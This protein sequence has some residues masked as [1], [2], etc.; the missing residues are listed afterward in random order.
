MSSQSARRNFFERPRVRLRAELDVALRRLHGKARLLVGSTTHSDPAERHRLCQCVARGEHAKPRWEWRPVAIERSVWRELARARELAEA[1]EAAALYLPRL[2]E[3]EIELLLLES[4]GR[5]KQVRP[6]AARLF[7]TGSERLFPDS[8]HSILD[9]AHEILSNASLEQ[10][11]KT[12]PAASVEGVNLRDLMLAY[13][14][15]VGLHIAV[16]I[17]P[18]LIANAAVGERTVFIAD[19]CFGAHEAQRLATHEVY[20]H[21]VS[22]F[23]GR[24]QTLGIFSIGTAGSYGDQEGVAIYLEELAG[25]LDSSRQRTLAGRLLATHAMHA[26]VSFGDAARV[27]VSEHD[28][29]PEAAVTLCER[30]FRAGGVARDAVYLTGWLRV[31]RAVARGETNLAEL[32]LGKVSLSALPELRRLARDGLLTQPVYLSNL[33]KS[34]G[35]TGAGTRLATLPPS[36]A[37]SLTRLDAT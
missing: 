33:A 2:E 1:S 14:K 17:D 20:G 4:L 16:R 11:E 24:T 27:L 6:M 5:S 12:I 34:L 26:G 9:A 8:N 25:L 30:A 15:H 21:L 32:Q 7:G 35:S 28:F 10:E 22:G 19:R 13:G 31:R 3:L 18:G 29:S 23:N 36:L 37:T